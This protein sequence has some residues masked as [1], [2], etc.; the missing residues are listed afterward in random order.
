MQCISL[1]LL[2]GFFSEK[3]QLIDTKQLNKFWVN[4][5]RKNFSEIHGTLKIKYI[6]SS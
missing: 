4:S 6:T 5:K 1:I 3:I 2:V